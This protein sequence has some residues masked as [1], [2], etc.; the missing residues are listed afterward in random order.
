MMPNGE[1]TRGDR[2]IEPQEAATVRRIFQDY[3]KGISPK[4]IAEQLN[5]EGIP[6]PQGGPWGTSTIHGNRDR[7]TGIL[8]NELYIGQ[9]I[10]NRLRYVKDPQTGKRVSS[11]APMPIGSWSPMTAPARRHCSS[12]HRQTAVPSGCGR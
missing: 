1:L 2:V 11:A 7:G 12:Q 8:N 10:W 4:K 5:L 3:A 6:G 9:Q